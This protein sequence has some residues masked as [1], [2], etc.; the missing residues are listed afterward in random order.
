MK[1]QLSLILLISLFT[2]ANAKVKALIIINDN[3][4]IAY[5]NFKA[6]KYG[7]KKEV[8]EKAIKGYETLKAK[9][10]LK[11]K[12][13]ITI[14]D[15]T[16][17]SKKKRFFVLDVET[18][19]VVYCL[20]VTHG[21]ASGDEFANQFSNTIDSHQTSLGFYTTGNEY[22]GENGSSLKLNGLE[23]GYNDNAFDRAVVI[24]GSEYATDEYFKA[25]N[26][27]GRS[28]GCP[29]ISSKEIA[30]VIKAIKNGSCLFIYHNDK[31]YH[32]KSK[33]LQ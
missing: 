15:M 32:K 9:G 3:T 1:K 5:N 33:L 8:F 22:I 30:K 19:K 29:A 16:M 4:P 18:K 25:N 12:R 6:S 13:Y 2:I 11:N 24:H 7:L 27:I 23:A 31:K 21:S 14:C 17:S 20:R 10:Q 26:K 28:W